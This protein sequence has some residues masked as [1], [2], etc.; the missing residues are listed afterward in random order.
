VIDGQ[1]YVLKDETIHVRDPA[2]IRRHDIGPDAQVWLGDV[3]AAR[4]AAVRHLPLDYTSAGFYADYIPWDG[5]TTPYTPEYYHADYDEWRMAFPDAVPIVRKVSIDGMPVRSEMGVYQ[6][7]K[8][9]KIDALVSEG[10]VARPDAVII[11]RPNLK[12][13]LQMRTEQGVAEAST[14]K[15]FTARYNW[16]NYT[17]RGLPIP[18]DMASQARM[19][20][21]YVQEHLTLGVEVERNLRLTQGYAF[22]GQSLVAMELGVGL[23]LVTGAAAWANPLLFLES[24]A[25]GIGADKLVTH[26][27]GSETLGTIAGLGAG[28]LAGLGRLPGATVAGLL[29]EQRA[30]RAAPYLATEVSEGVMLLGARHPEVVGLGSVRRAD[31]AGALATTTASDSTALVLSRTPITA[32]WRALPAPAPGAPMVEFGSGWRRPIP[33][34]GEKH[35]PPGTGVPAQGIAAPPQGTSKADW[36]AYNE[37]MLPEAG[38]RIESVGGER[39]FYVGPPMSNGGV[40]VTAARFTPRGVM[41]D[42]QTHVGMV[43][44]AANEW[45]AR[46]PGRNLL[47]GTSAHGGTT[48]GGFGFGSGLPSGRLIPHPPFMAEDLR[49]LTPQGFPMGSGQRPLTLDPNRAQV[50]DFT[51]QPGQTTIVNALQANHASLAADGVAF[52]QC[53]STFTNFI[54]G[55]VP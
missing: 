31:V 27:T 36:L 24:A 11:E 48:G 6:I 47:V 4:E 38:R 1:V 46:N 12:T 49:T 34:M 32:P 29:A 17:S 10:G 44:I 19:A 23:G 21:A 5:D 26:V 43:N 51:A 53:Y 13:P 37:S 3:D 30:A 18:R 40:N 35:V 15:S 20:E 52:A 9:P 8:D 16:Q 28:M 54:Q 42:T 50:V 22:L 41:F 14:P 45:L 55:K 7:G 2:A 33:L 25:V 39:I